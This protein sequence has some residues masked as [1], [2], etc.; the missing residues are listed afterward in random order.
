MLKI[1]PQHDGLDIIV[2][3]VILHLDL[4]TTLK[5]MLSCSKINKL[6]FLAFKTYMFLLEFNNISQ[7]LTF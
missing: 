7:K 4:T 3:S 6:Y 5:Y 2:M 1:R